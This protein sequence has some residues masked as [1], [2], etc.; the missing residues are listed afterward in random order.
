MVFTFPG[1]EIGQ[2]PWSNMLKRTSLL[3]DTQEN[4]VNFEQDFWQNASV[5][6]NFA[7]FP[8]QY[9]FFQWL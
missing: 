3:R 1:Q 5:L 7:N 9:H 4:E 8:N 6:S 2:L